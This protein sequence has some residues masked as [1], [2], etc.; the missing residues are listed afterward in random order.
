MTTDTIDLDN[1]SIRETAVRQPVAVVAEHDFGDAAMMALVSGLGHRAL[2]VDLDRARVFCPEGIRA[3]IVRSAKHLARVREPGR[4]D[5]AHI[6][7]IGVCPG[8]EYGVELPDSP[9]AAGT[10]R[11]VLDKVAGD[12]TGDEGRVQLSDRECEVVLTYV[13]GATVRETA[14]RHFIAE[15][16]VRTHLRR[17]SDRYIAVGRPVANK[18]QLLIELMADGWVDRDHLLRR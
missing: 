8:R 7:G 3:V 10:L 13:L 4:F 16:T 6:I 17:V 18:S 12:V 5:R 2:L 15:S 9:F 14:T 1:D 11:Q